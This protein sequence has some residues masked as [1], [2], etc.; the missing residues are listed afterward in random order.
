MTT[1]EYGWRVPDF[2][3]DGS[4]NPTFLAQIAASLDRVRGRFDS[5]WVA[6]HVVPWSK[7]QAIETPTVEC[8]TTLTFLAARYPELT[9][10]P[11]VLCQSYRNPALLA[12]MVANLSAFLPGKIVF[13]IGAG[14]KQGE[15]RAYGWPFPSAGTRLRQMTDT[16]VIAR[17]LW[18]EDNVTYEGP[19]YQVHDAYL[20]PKPDPLPPIMIGGGGERTTLKIVAQHADWWNIPGG[21]RENYARKLEILRG[22]CAEIGRDFDSIRKTW[23]CEVV[24]VARTSAEARRIAEA[25]PFYGGEGLIGT[26]DEVIAQLRAWIA[27]GVTHFQFRFADFPRTGGVELFMDEV[28]SH[29]KTA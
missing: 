8:W 12:K 21:S 19:E 3:T 7:W 4:D 5:A 20:N 14:W 24:A 10:G 26:P 18:T 22:Y 6:D 1:I 17:R 16:I 15:Y 9:W 11:I 2:P 13:G 29:V 28:L 27:L 25:S 23:A